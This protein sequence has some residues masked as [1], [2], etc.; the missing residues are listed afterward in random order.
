MN[1]ITAAITAVGAYVPDF[2][3]SNKVLET[4]VD[5]NDEWI[6]TRTGIKER[7]ILKD[8]DKGTSFLAIKAAQD[9]IAKANIDPLEIDMIIMATATADMPV[10]STGVYV[11]TEIG[12]TNAF[13]YDLQ[14]ACSSFLYGM[15]TAAAYIQSGRYKKVLLIGADKMSS[16]VDY[17]DRSTCIIFGDGAGAVLFEP[18][19]EGLGL[20]DEYLRSDGVGRDFL[21]IPAGGSLIPTTLETVQN[22]RHNIIQDGKTVFK[23]AVTNMA[24]SSE[25]ILKRNNLTNQ[26]VNWLVPHQANK[27]IIDATAHRMNLE[28][29]KVLMN[30]ERYGNTTSA[31]LPLVLS[32]FEHLFK[33]GD[34]IIFAAFGGGFT[35]GSIYLKWAYDKK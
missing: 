34:N 11:A 4:M 20:Q 18:N 24:D 9:L 35:W 29:S 8:T 3:L 33:K 14:A 5:T 27:R 32:D 19:Y 1:T 16:I 30:I 13:A 23:Y 31:T 12:A 25:L 21:K 7:R 26:D 2:V 28:D 6:T 22:N 17:T 15:S 10:A